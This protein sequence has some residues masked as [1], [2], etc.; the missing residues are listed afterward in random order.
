[1]SPWRNLR[2]FLNI[3]RMIKP[4]HP[5]DDEGFPLNDSIGG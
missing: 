2:A 5:I 4:K 1:M 3:K